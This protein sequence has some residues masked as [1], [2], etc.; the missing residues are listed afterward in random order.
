MHCRKNCICTANLKRLFDGCKLINNGILLRKTAQRARMAPSNLHY[1]YTHNI[2]TIQEKARRAAPTFKANETVVR[3][4]QHYANHKCPFSH[5]DLI[6]FVAMQSF[7]GQCYPG[8]DSWYLNFFPTM[9]EVQCTCTTAQTSGFGQ[10]GQG[11][12]QSA[13]DYSSGWCQEV[14][15]YFINST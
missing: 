7:M 14:W 6:K 10:V 12:G 8:A 2:K 15:S 4:V 9:S 13:I 5:H 11:S 1:Q 3:I